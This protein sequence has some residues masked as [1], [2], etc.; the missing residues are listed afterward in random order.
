MHASL[1][2]PKYGEHNLIVLIHT[3]LWNIYTTIKTFG[4]NNINIEAFECRLASK[5]TMI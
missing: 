1:I 5:Q 3:R 2:A 4:K